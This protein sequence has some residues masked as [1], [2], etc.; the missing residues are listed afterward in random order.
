MAFKAECVVSVKDH[1]SAAGC[2]WPDANRGDALASKGPCSQ[3]C[4]NAENELAKHDRRQIARVKRRGIIH[5]LRSSNFIFGDELIAENATFSGDEMM[6]FNAG[7][8]IVI[9]CTVNYKA[10]A[11]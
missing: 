9:H 8:G 1:L 10:C 2:R 7:L 3:C 5:G 11:I 6:N 4:H